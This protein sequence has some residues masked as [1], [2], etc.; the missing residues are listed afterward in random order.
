VSPLPGF[1]ALAGLG[2]L[3]Q[4][5]ARMKAVQE[6]LAGLTVEG[7]AGGGLVRVTASGTG[8]IVAV[9][10]DPALAAGPDGGRTGELVAAASNA[11]LD[12][13]RELAARELQEALGGL[14]PPGMGAG[15]GLPGI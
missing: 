12:R 15:L 14:V 10:I 3:A 8:R 11:A 2:K 5:P 6:K 4:L 7:E 13:V 9:V 1:G